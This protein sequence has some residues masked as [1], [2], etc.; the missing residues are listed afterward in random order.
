[1]KSHILLVGLLLMAGLAL[2]A[3]YSITVTYPNGGETVDDTITL[4]ADYSWDILDVPN[5]TF[6][7]QVNFYYTRSD[8]EPEYIDTYDIDLYEECP[9][10]YQCDGQASVDWDT[11][12]VEN[13]DDYKILARLIDDLLQTCV[14]TD[15]G[16]EDITV[17]CEDMIY[18]EDTSDNYFTVRDDGGRANQ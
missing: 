10:V 16:K 5:Y 7:T 17:V 8:G 11:T 6:P 1:M 12:E 2:A 15:Y 18:S 4:T 9:A 3:Y 13:G 14:I